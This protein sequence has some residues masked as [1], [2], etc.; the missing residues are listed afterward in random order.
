MTLIYCQDLTHLGLR[1]GDRTHAW[2]DGTDRILSNVHDLSTSLHTLILVLN[3]KYESA[4]PVLSLNLPQ[5]RSLEMGTFSV[6]D[7]SEAMAFWR[8]HP[9]IEKL[10]LSNTQRGDHWFSE[11]VDG[12][13]LPNLIYLEVSMVV[14][15][16]FIPL[17]RRNIFKQILFSP[18]S[19]MCS[20]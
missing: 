5:L 2:D 3:Y 19:V 16:C 7:T 4:S 9:L 12:D 13:L 11:T 8:R 14:S 1:F 18:A 20:F 10:K 17:G 15:G 6:P